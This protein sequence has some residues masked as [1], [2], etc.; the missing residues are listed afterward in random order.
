M[1]DPA[2]GRWYCQQCWLAPLQPAPPVAVE[3][4]VCQDC[5]EDSSGKVDDASGKWYCGR[6]WNTW[7]TVAP[8][9]A[10]STLPCTLSCAMP[11]HAPTV[12][13]YIFM[14]DS[15]TVGDNLSNNI[16]GAPNTLPA[17]VVEGCSIFIFNT[18]S[19]VLHGPF[20]CSGPPGKDLL[21]PASLPSFK[22]QYRF[23]ARFTVEFK[24]PPLHLREIRQLLEWEEQKKGNK[25]GK[26]KQQLTPAVVTALKRAFSA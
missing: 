20:C 15:N 11:T 3:T 16:V 8:V 24:A 12:A 13:G 9:F 14:A 18:T 5:C 22:G 1:V 21:E 19:K 6:C 26:F 2:N 25:N 23:Q 4:Q 7:N 17:A 10:S